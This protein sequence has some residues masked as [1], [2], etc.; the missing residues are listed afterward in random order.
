MVKFNTWIRGKT[1]SN[2]QHLIDDTPYNRVHQK[3]SWSSLKYVTPINTYSEYAHVTAEHKMLIAIIIRAV[4]DSTLE[5]VEQCT[6]RDARR[7]IHSNNKSSWSFLWVCEHLGVS[8]TLIKRIRR[9]IDENDPRVKKAHLV[10]HPDIGSAEQPLLDQIVTV[11]TEHN[12][13]V[14]HR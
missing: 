2:T 14:P 12:S 5:T 7:W 1:L 11:G 3:Y 10:P 13:Y 6:Y 9:Y 4:T 8:T